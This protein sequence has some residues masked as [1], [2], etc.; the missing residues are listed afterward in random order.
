[1]LNIDWNAP[2][3]PCQT[4]GCSWPN[5]HV[6]IKPGTP[7]LF[8]VLL[9]ELAD[10]PRRKHRRKLSERSDEHKAAISAAQIERWARIRELNKQ[11]DAAMVE[12]YIDGL[13]YRQLAAEFDVSKTTVIKVLSDAADEG[14]LTIRPSGNK[15][16]LKERDDKIIV[17]YKTGIEVPELSQE[18]KLSR[19]VVQ[20]ILYNARANGK[21]RIR[22]RWDTS[23][24]AQR[25]Q[26]ILE[27][28]EDRQL[29]YAE[30]AEMFSI[31]KATVVAVVASAKK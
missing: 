21:L 4:E 6:C 29:I 19:S 18:F 23:A 26:K 8:P 20:R 27:L 31:S 1:M 13:S 24:Q 17:A 7:D 30:I 22:P 9:G 2:K 11:R 10:K 15:Q 5:Y 28:V 16:D 12:R 14:L 3:T 25:N